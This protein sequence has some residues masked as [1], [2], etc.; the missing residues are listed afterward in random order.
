MQITVTS[1]R[2]S[3]FVHVYIPKRSKSMIIIMRVQIWW[4]SKWL[5]VHVLCAYVYQHPDVTK[6]LLEKRSSIG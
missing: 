2:N 5:Q 6:S 1:I 3:V 4:F